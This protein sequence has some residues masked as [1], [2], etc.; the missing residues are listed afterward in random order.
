MAAPGGVAALARLSGS[1]ALAG[2]AAAGCSSCL[3]EPSLLAGL[4]ACFHPATVLFDGS[5]EQQG[6]ET[7]WKQKVMRLARGRGPETFY[8][9]DTAPHGVHFTYKVCMHPLMSSATKQVLCW[10]EVLFALSTIYVC[11]VTHGAMQYGLVL[12]VWVMQMHII[13]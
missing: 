11:Y 6:E 13:S 10:S 1:F 8:A 12:Y 9:L 4:A 3:A 7:P 5:T 2:V